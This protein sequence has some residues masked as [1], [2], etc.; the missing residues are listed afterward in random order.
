[1]FNLF[2]LVYVK[3]GGKIGYAGPFGPQYLPELKEL[4][5]RHEPS[6][7]LKLVDTWLR[8]EALASRIKEAEAGDLARIESND[9]LN[10]QNRGGGYTSGRLYNLLDKQ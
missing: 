6:P 2:C 5:D 9:L 8:R 1:V 10:A 7:L 3:N 4:L